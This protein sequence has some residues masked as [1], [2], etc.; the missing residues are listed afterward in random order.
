MR[1]ILYAV[2]GLIGLVLVAVGVIAAAGLAL[3]ATHL[4]ARTARLHRPAAAVWSTLLDRASHPSWRRDLQRLEPLADQGGKPSFREVS[5]HGTIT[6]VVDEATPPTATTPGRLVVRIA[7]ET[8]PF[9]GRWI[10]DVVPDGPDGTGTRL[11]ITEDGI[12]RNPVFRFL[13]RFVFGH[14]ATL[15]AFLRDLS[16]HLGDPATPTAAAPTRLTA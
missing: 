10:Y 8:L 15:D 12:V 14:T 16:A 5:K 7:D 1:W 6:F 3:S 9:G 4:V 13:S 2:V 11:T